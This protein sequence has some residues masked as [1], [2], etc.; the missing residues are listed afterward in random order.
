MFKL[1]QNRYYFYNYKKIFNRSLY[2]LILFIPNKLDLN[3]LKQKDI[4]FFLI[5]KNL[6]KVFFKVNFS[7]FTGFNYFFVFKNFEQL[8]IYQNFL[9]KYSNIVKIFFYKI[10]NYFISVNL[11]NIIKKLTSKFQNIFL[12]H[13][14]FFFKILFFILHF[15]LFFYSFFTINILNIYKLKK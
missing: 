10:N 7:L 4:N 2:G 12:F 15:F 6:L 8:L 13:L 5:K 11:F 1:I 14:I 9:V 3:I